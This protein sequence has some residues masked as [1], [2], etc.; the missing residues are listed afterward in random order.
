MRKVTLNSINA[1]IE[2]WVAGNKKYK[3]L[4]ALI[5]GNLDSPNSKRARIYMAQ[6]AITEIRQEIKGMKPTSYI[7]RQQILHSY[8]F[9]HKLQ[10]LVNNLEFDIKRQRAI[11]ALWA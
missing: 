4:H 11:Q 7:H 1:S 10:K 6:T 3:H 9:V 2:D 8:R 5:A